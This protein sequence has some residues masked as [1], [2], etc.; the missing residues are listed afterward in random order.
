MNPFYHEFS[1][2]F[3]I[4]MVVM[5]VSCILVALLGL[6]QYEREGM[7]I[8][9]CFDDRVSLVV[10]IVLAAVFMVMVLFESFDGV[11]Q[12][13]DNTSGA[14]PAWSVFVAPF[15]IMLIGVIQ[16]SILYIIN[17]VAKLAKIGWLYEQIQ[18]AKFRRMKREKR[19]IEKY[20]RMH[21]RS[22]DYSSMQITSIL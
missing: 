15:A 16:W 2:G 4:W 20:K 14:D 22:Q 21:K 12:Y 10:T 7:R 9:R 17:Y 8:V 1:I 5:I 19:R 11:V 18:Q 13:F 6:K 3:N